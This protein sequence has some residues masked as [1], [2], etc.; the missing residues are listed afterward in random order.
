MDTAGFR[1]LKLQSPENGKETLSWIFKERDQNGEEQIVGNPPDPTKH[2][3]IAISCGRSRKTWVVHRSYCGGWDFLKK[4]LG[5]QNC[6]YRQRNGE[7]VLTVPK[8]MRGS[9]VGYDAKVISFL[10]AMISAR[11]IQINEGDAQMPE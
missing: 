5:K 3:L 11:H 4:A 2:E 9:W 10:T 8:G 6:N 1:R 7:L